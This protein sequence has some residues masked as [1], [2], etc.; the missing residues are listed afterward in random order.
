MQ[1][2]DKR[3]EASKCRDF[4]MG[5]GRYSKT[6]IS[7]RMAYTYNPDKREGDGGG[8]SVEHTPSPPAP[9]KEA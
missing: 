6:A 7:R 5:R 3:L 2:G 8:A 9:I 1:H 4:W